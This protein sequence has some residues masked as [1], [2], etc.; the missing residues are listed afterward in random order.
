M[1]KKAEYKAGE[2]VVYPTHGVG[3][4][5]GTV[6]EEV[7]GSALDLLVIKFPQDRMTLRIPVA[8][9]GDSGLRRL[10]S[11]KV[12]DEALAKLRGRA[13]VRRT[14]WSRRAQEYE[15]KINS[16][17]PA[18]IAEVVR[19]LRRNTTQSEQSYSERQMYQVA[20]DRL[21]R[22]VAAIERIDQEKA[23]TRLEK[24][25]TVV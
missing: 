17:N 11:R 18:A 8:K 20:L 25:M 14:M 21:S 16:G 12:M 19:D 3:E 10:S 13:K 4:V 6:T 15:A 2:F 5:I 9:A 24:I 7:L 1:G 23:A 22:E